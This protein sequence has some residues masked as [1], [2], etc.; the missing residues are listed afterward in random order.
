MIA[1]TGFSALELVLG[2]TKSNDED[3]V[4][5]QKV[6]TRRP[7]YLK[8]KKAEDILFGDKT[9]EMRLFYSLLCGCIMTEP[10]TVDFLELEVYL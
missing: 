3:P 5:T 9:V 7:R 10:L 1:D 4:A 2:R 6:T 8:N